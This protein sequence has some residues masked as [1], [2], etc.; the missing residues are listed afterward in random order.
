MAAFCRKRLSRREEHRRALP[1]P[2]HRR[3]GSTGLGLAFA[4]KPF[5]IAFV[6][7][8][9]V[10]KLRSDLGLSQQAFASLLGL[11]FVSINKWENDA[12][13]PT[14]LSAVLLE[15]LQN[16]LRRHGRERVLGKLRPLG[17]VPIEVVRTL[18][19]LER[20]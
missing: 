20:S 17:G 13:A 19:A 10:K 14:G 11:S 16:A 7:P 15:L 9:E 12:S 6:T 18:T 1:R 8:H 4:I 2:V 3:P 5:I